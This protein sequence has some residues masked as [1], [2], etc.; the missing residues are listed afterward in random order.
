MR[1]IAVFDFDGTLTKK[2]SMIEY[3]I[4]VGGRIRVL[5]ALLVCLPYLMLMKTGLFSN[6]KVKSLFLRKTLLGIRR[7]Y[8]KEKGIQFTP[9]IDSFLREDVVT[10]LDK[11][12]SNGDIVYVVSASAEE[13]IRPWCLQHGI[14]NIICTQLEFDEQEKFTGRLAGKNCYGQEKVLRFLNVEPERA[15]Y[16][17]TAYGDSRGDK[18]MIAFADEGIWL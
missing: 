6:E 10:M 5:S 18:E 13:W 16:H 9:I 11:H 12:V 17:L 7:E 1:N 2:D 3:T 8:L 15:S 4:F 14:S